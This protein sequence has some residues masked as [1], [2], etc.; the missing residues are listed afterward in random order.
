MKPED[1]PIWY[2]LY[3]AYPP[4]SEPRFDRKPS[5]TQIKNIFYP[6]DKIRA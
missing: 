6:E 4:I 1:R 3:A 2:D 5:T